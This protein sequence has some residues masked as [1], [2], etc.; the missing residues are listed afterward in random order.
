[1]NTKL[2]IGT[3]AIVN[4]N[5]LTPSFFSESSLGPHNV[6]SYECPFLP[7][8]LGIHHGYHHRLRRV[9]FLNYKGT[10]GLCLLIQHP[11]QI[12]LL[13]VC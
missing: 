8:R 10:H 6:C 9:R 11:K 7:M 12:Y 1:M 2:F 4:Q 13:K 5:A 3:P